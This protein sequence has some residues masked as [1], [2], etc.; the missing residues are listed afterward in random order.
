MAKSQR[1]FALITEIDVRPGQ[2]TKQLAEKFGCSLRTIQRDIDQL[3]DLG[4]VP[5][6]DDGYRFR[7]K[8]FLSPLALTRDE[9]V[10]IILA[11]RL[12]ARQLDGKASKALGAAVDKMRR[13]M[14]A[15]D[16]IMAEKIEDRTAVL[17]GG[18]TSL[19]VGNDQFQELTD[20]V[21]RHQQITFDYQGRDDQAKE[22]RHVEPLGLSFQDGRWYLHA[23]DIRRDGERTFRLGRMSQLRVS[24]VRFEPKVKFT[25]EKAAFHQWDLGEGDP[26]ELNLTTTPGLARWFEENKPHPSVTVTGKQV[27]LT[28][29]DPDSFLRWFASLDDAE[30]TSP[31]HCRD[32][33]RAR[34]SDLHSRY[35][36]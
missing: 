26:V 19:D 1:W 22:E 18:D 27:T 21:Q 9:V 5:Y 32:R 6:N 14:C 34:L 8:P 13:G 35:V 2:T 12:A 15:Q 11:Q 7:H 24:S 28:V 29:N 4:F 20:A 31:A 17:P 25:T 33:L 23:F 16:K 30:L 36:T 3:P 10:S